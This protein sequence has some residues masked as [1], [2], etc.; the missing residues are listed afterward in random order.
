MNILI[1]G[2]NGFVGSALMWKLQSEDHKVIGI[3][4]SQHC[5]DKAHP[6]THIGDI[7]HLDDLQIVSDIFFK[8]H[9]KQIELIIHC[10]AAKHDYG[11]KK[12]EY[13]SH[14]EHGTKVLLDFIRNNNISKLIY[15][16]TVSVFGH[17]IQRTD[18]DGEF[19]PDHPYGASKLAGEILCTNWQKENSKH[20]LIVLRP[21]VIYGPHNYANMYKLIDMM[22]RRPYVMIG[23]GNYIKS[24]VSLSN[25][26]DMTAFSMT[27]IKPDTQY[28]NCVDKPYITLKHLM[29]IIAQNKLFH[30]PG[31]S[32]P[33]ILAIFIGKLFDIP[34]KLFKIDLPINSDRM[35]KLATATDFAS[36][37]IREAGYI[38][39]HTIEDEI[40]ATTDW[41]L[42]TRKRGFK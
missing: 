34:A 10:A 8:L 39:T 42:S 24:I 38:Q 5:D 35:Y 11:I 16:S 36:E 22:H 25:I 13:F 30:I 6:E 28:Y 15:F 18:E 31:V 2:S 33:V 29:Q 3:D 19:A 26:I 17:P 12:E 1:T 32:I 41:Y 4:I 20:E 9:K 23:S 14:N 21:T 7:R 40:K 37:R 27:M